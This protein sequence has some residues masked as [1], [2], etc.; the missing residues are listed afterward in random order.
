ML[1]GCKTFILQ[2]S[3]GQI[4]LTHSVSAGLDYA[5]I[6]P[7]HAY[8]RDRGRI[9]YAH[10]S[11]DEVLEVFQLFSRLEGILP[12]LESTHALVHGIKRAK[13]MGKDEILIINLS[14]R[15]DKD[16]AQ[17]Q[18]LLDLEVSSSK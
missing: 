17:V 3:D 10:A 1:Q 15:G 11:D 4:E 12:A 2:D 6:G 18:Q 16:V 14:G 13:E 7:E 9:D 5:G 8:Y